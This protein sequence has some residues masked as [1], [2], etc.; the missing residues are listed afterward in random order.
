[1]TFFL[2]P[3]NS[4]MIGMFVLLYFAYQFSQVLDRRSR[5]QTGKINPEILNYF[6][7]YTAFDGKRFAT[8][9]E[10]KAY[11]ASLAPKVTGE[12]FNFQTQKWEPTFAKK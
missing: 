5:K 12:R 1:M 10:A 2:F 6:L 8:L 4:M 11:V 3:L 9:A 7:P